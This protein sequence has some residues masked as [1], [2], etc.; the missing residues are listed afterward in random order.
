MVYLGNISLHGG[1]YHERLLF[2]L[3]IDLCNIVKTT[4][5]L[6]FG[7]VGAMENRK[8]SAIVGFPVILLAVSTIL[9]SALPCAA[10]FV[11]V[12][13]PNGDTTLNVDYTIEESVTV[14]AGG[15]LNLLDGGSINGIFGVGVEDG[16]TLN[17]NGG[18]I[19][20]DVYAADGSE[21]NI[22]GGSIGG[23][24]YGWDITLYAGA[25][26]TVFGTDFNVTDGTIDPSGTYFTPDKWPPP[27]LLE[28][29]Y[30]G[31]AGD[32]NLLFC[33]F[34]DIH[35]FLAPPA[36]EVTID[37]KPGSNQNT[38][39]LKSKGVVPV[40]VLTAD[41]FFADTIDPETALLAGA[42]PEHWSFEDVDDDGDIDVIF[43][44]RT[45][46]LALD[47]NSA[48]ATLT[49]ELLTGEEVSGTDEIRVVPSKKSK[50]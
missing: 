6:D 38:I 16:G 15:T 39:N 4:R 25:K 7:G 3:R 13:L 19:S 29:T 12:P 5:K 34:D 24:D 45:Q 50:K 48:E 44:F 43:H 42:T 41:G 18:Y 2:I 26:V 33:V 37:I 32:I 22:K 35:I 17:I 21:V 20:K 40:A 49:A 47:Q 30:G 36:L 11:V 1:H 31:D 27:C 10:Q 28:G 8:K 9:L 23:N 46:E 14:Q